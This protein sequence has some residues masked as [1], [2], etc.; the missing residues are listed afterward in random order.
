MSRSKRGL[1]FFFNP[2]IAIYLSSSIHILEV[3][4]QCSLPSVT[5]K[6]HGPHLSSLHWDMLGDAKNF[7]YEN[8]SHGLVDA[9]DVHFSCYG[10]D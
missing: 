8:L 9:W 4:E 6:K 7:M 1:I 3:S 10:I 2:T 5:L